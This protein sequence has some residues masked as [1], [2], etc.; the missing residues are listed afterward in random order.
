MSQRLALG[1]LVGSALLCPV[2]Q[3]V[4]EKT[5]TP[6]VMRQKCWEVNN[7][8]PNPEHA[9]FSLISAMVMGVRGF[10]VVPAT[11]ADQWV[12]PG[13]V[14]WLQ[15]LTHT[16]AEK[17]SQLRTGVLPGT[18]ARPATNFEWF[19][20]FSTPGH[21][22]YKGTQEYQEC[23]PSGLAHTFNDAAAQN[24]DAASFAAGDGAAASSEVVN[25]VRKLQTPV[26]VPVW[27][28][29][30]HWMTMLRVHALNSLVDP[31][32]WDV[33]FVEMYDGFLEGL[34]NKDLQLKNNVK[35]TPLPGTT[36][37][38][39]GR[40]TVAADMFLAVYYQQVGFWGH[41]CMDIFDPMDPRYPAEA[42]INQGD[43]WFNRFVMLYDPPPATSPL[44]TPEPPMKMEFVS[45]PGVWQKG[46]QM[47]APEAAAAT[48]QSLALS[49]IDGIEAN[50][51]AL[52]GGQAGTAILVEGVQPSSATWRYFAVPWQQPDGTLSAI[53]LLS[54]DD[55]RVQLFTALDHPVKTAPVSAERARGEAAKIL[56]ADESLAGWRVRWDARAGLGGARSPNRPYYAI[57]VLDGSGSDRG[58][59]LVAWLG[60]EVLGRFRSL[61]GQPERATTAPQ[62]NP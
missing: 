29:W 19:E 3:A 2:S 27:G 45:A 13:G 42:C 40:I 7:P 5:C 49:G 59:I 10:K 60:G 16:C 11:P 20:G 48:L 15:M 23:N 9:R 37:D 61:P 41:P 55:G 22:N 44:W 30:D 57:D 25:L 54:A 33:K 32:L 14:N 34:G 8:N 17:S 47:S 58:V 24:W 12:P 56:A 43:T 6:L 21:P 18:A 62:P 26:V 31:K 38:L 36:F 1:I 46:R 4:A 53:A 50:R 28:S 39:T 52:S 35:D 51:S